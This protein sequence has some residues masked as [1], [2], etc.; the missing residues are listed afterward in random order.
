MNV[1]VQLVRW[2][3]TTFVKFEYDEGN[4]TTVSHI[5]PP[6]AMVTDNKQ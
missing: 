2:I 6:E 3:T 4:Q 1:R 5:E